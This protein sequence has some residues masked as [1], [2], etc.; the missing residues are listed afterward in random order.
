MYGSF[1]H[2][3]IR[4]TSGEHMRRLEPPTLRGDLDTARNIH[5]VAVDG[6]RGRDNPEYRRSNAAV[7]G[8]RKRSNDP[9]GRAQLG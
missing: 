4:T 5:H 2:E 7:Y 8:P 3:A 1:R 6:D 9:N